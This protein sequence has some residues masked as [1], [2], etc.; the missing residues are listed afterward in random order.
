MKSIDEG[1]LESLDSL[2]ITISG[3]VV[4]VESRGA[5]VDFSSMVREIEV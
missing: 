3:D 1:L 5:V 2:P 4:S